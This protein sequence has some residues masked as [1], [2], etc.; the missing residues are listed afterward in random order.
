MISIRKKHFLKEA[1]IKNFLYNLQQKSEIIEKLLNNY[2][3]K[4]KTI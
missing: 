3:L 2:T 1:F 4:A